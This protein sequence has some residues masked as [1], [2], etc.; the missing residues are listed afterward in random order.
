MS[1]GVAAVI[2]AGGFSSRMGE[3]KPLLSLG[4]QTL[5]ERCSGLFRQAG[6]D[7]ILAVTGHRAE[8]VRPCLERLGIEGVHN[9]RHAEGMFTSVLAGVQAL[10]PAVEAFFLL[11][12][13]TPLVRSSS[14]AAL[15]RAWEDR[16]GQD[17][18]H[19]ALLGRRGHPPLTGG[20]H[21]SPILAWDGKMGLA[22]YF[23]D[24]EARHPGQ[25]R[26]VEV[27]DEMIL[28][29][30]DHPADVRAAAARLERLAIPSPDE[31]LALL[32]I[33]GASPE[34][35]AHGLGVAL[36]GLRLAAA[37]D[38]AKCPMDLDKV[39]AAGLLHD[40]ARGMPDHALAGADLLR[41]AGFSG[42]ADTVAGHM[43]LEG[44]AGGEVTERE[45]LYLADKYVRGAEVVSLEERFSA[46]ERRFAG[47][48]QALA[49]LA[50]RREKALALR[51]KMAA[52]LGER[53]ETVLLHRSGTKQEGRLHALFAAPR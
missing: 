23:S 41:R 37:L 43:D 52:I 14:V 7:R 50:A 29:D 51:H 6:V 36:A 18:L 39:A 35:R 4:G 40:V 49:G 26:A 53:P 19:P 38:R 46:K 25:V 31:C 42:V 28:F 10:P 32:N 12:V 27:A 11:P 13:D 22:G 8:E 47:D 24:F 9:E 45:V 3:F 33:T 5:L 44:G 2:L 20:A 34:L 15:L 30:L 1:A 16:G 17:I 21:I 48:P